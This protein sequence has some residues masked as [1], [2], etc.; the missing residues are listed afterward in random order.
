MTEVSSCVAILRSCRPDDGA[1][2]DAR[3]AALQLRTDGN[4]AAASGQ[5]AQAE[6]LLSA[7]LRSCAGLHV[8]RLSR[9]ASRLALG[10]LDGALEDATAVAAAAGAPTKLRARAHL[11]AAS[12]H[13]AAGD[14]ARAAAACA[15]AAAVDA[16]IARS[17]EYVAATQ[18]AAKLASQA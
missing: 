5:H 13:T 15:A 16:S 3:V 1:E 4:A 14:G 9:A 2:L 11:A 6:E 17:K 8:A 18:A 7:A 10:A 12:A